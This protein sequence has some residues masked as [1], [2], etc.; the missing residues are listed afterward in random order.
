MLRVDKA[1][2]DTN[3]VICEN[4]SN[5]KDID[6][7]LLSQNILSNLRNFV[8]YIAIKEYAGGKDI[9]PNDYDINVA[10]LKYIPTQAKLS[11]LYK[12]H[13]MLQKSVSH[14]TI[15]KDGSERLMLKYYEYLLKIK[16]YL[17]YNYGMETLQNIQQ[18]PLN[19]DTELNDYYQKIAERIESPSLM[20]HPITY[21]DR[22]Y[23][24]KVKPFYV[25][26]NIYYEVTFT[27]VNAKISKFDRVIAFSKKDITDNYAVQFKIHNDMINVLDRDMTIQIIDDWNVSIRPCELSNF[28]WIFG[29]KVEFNTNSNEYRNLMRFLTDSGI[30]LTDLISSERKYYE[31]LKNQI[32][33]G[34][35]STKIS[36]LFDCCRN[37][38]ANNRAGANVLRYLLY[39][40]NNRIIKEQLWG[41]P[42]K[43]LSNL[44][45]S[46][47]CIP[48]D[49]MPFC[50]SLCN[51][52]PK[53]YDLYEVIPAEGRDHEFLARCVKNNTEKEGRLFTPVKELGDFDDINGLIIKYNDLLYSKHTN[54][55]LELFND[56][57]FINEYAEDSKTIICKLQDL[58]SYG[59]SQYTESVDYWLSTGSYKIDDQDK[60]NALRLMFGDSRVALVYGAA[61]TGKSTMINHI[62]NFW[63][64]NDKLFLAN[65]HPA[66]DNMRRKVSA[67]NCTYDTIAKFLG[68]GYYKTKCDILFI[69]ECSTVSNSDM[70]RV[71]EKAEF[72]LL[73]LVG[74]I[75]QIE[76]IYFGNWFSIARKFMPDTAVFE[77]TH[78]FRTESK[79]LR[80][81][82]NRVRNLDDSILE[83]LVKNNYVARLDDSIFEHKTE[84]EIILCLNYDGL[85][86]INNI[87]R[88]L[89]N[90]NPNKEIMWGIKTYKVGDPILFN[91]FNI[92][93]PL[94]HNNS[95]GKIFGIQILERS[96]KFDIELD[97]TI[98]EIDA[99]GYKFELL[100]KSASDK[101]VISFEVNKH[102][103]TDE[104]DDDSDSTVVPFQ[105]AYA[106]SIHKAQGLEYDSVKIVITKEIEERITHNIF[107]TAITRAKKELKI[108]WSPETE[109]YV[110]ER[111]E[112]KNQN[113]DAY[114]LAQLYQLKM[115]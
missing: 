8:E 101:S 22:Y 36:N 102:R 38:I 69:D 91:E 19:I 18:F 6:R 81:V 54:R 49:K 50:T 2:L 26:G 105:V 112:T 57:I 71:L 96:I 42:C 115:K 39:K 44:K 80:T 13:K 28:S 24:Q 46:Y 59:V 31:Y 43:L 110:L 85:Y 111:L 14:Y 29:T 77:L 68:K 95:K 98:N 53:I 56:H 1:I 30:S 10:A 40:M 104:D 76:S 89:Q 78:P 100:G 27:A 37:I 90:C 23:V 11:F 88:F 4:I 113:K 41:E 25:N 82:W 60:S 93:S 103:S 52:N 62:A 35:K 66:V 20:N 63:S 84:D 5:L 79:E 67:G 16:N 75:Y 9:N 70:R 65:T 7:G 33:Q 15:D 92:F 114:L 99:I 64:K 86:G 58:S 73:V 97:E 34:V 94:I 106:I 83:P 87:N 55:K 47:G 51:H 17:K 12:F 3:D 61:G 72:K 107:Y 109:K 48:F 108:Y 74:D 45:L 32:T 21:N